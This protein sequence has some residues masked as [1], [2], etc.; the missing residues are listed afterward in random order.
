MSG[1]PSGNVKIA[2]TT[3]SGS[4]DYIQRSGA[5]TTNPQNF[6]VVLLVC[7]LAS[8][9]G[10][11]GGVGESHENQPRIQFSGVFTTR[12][13]STAGELH[14]QLSRTHIL[15]CPVKQRDRQECPSYFRK[16]LETS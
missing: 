8:N 1:L 7:N 14:T 10:R 6:G 11:L 5:V 15:V 13:Q 3:V 16:D 9:H 12:L 2:L 4:A